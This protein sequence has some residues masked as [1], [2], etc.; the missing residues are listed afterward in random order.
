MLRLYKSNQVSDDGACLIRVVWRVGDDR[1][2]VA[3]RQSERT[4]QMIGFGG[5][6]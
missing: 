1:G 4:S 5:I 6:E 2:A 3:A